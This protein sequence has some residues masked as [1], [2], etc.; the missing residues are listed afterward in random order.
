MLQGR[1]EITLKHGIY[2]AAAAILAVVLASCGG[3]RGIQENLDSTEVGMIEMERVPDGEY[4]GRYSAFPVSARV[5]VTVEDH[6]V[7]QIEILR[8]FNGQGEAGEGV[9]DSVIAAQ[10]LDVDVVSGATYSSRVILKA[11]E[12]AL[13]SGPAR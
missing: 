11:I 7:S 2:I 10:S 8:H 12:K 3:A 5:R 6:T 4:V 1:G 9:V 13:S